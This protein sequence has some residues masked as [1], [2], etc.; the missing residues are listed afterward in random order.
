MH[1]HSYI[2][3]HSYICNLFTISLLNSSVSELF[4]TLFY[5]YKIMI[6]H[7]G[8]LSTLVLSYHLYFLSLDVWAV[9]R[10]IQVNS[11]AVELSWSQPLKPNGLLSHYQLLRD[12]VVVFSGDGGKMS[13]TD[14][15]LQP[16][17]R[18]Y[19]SAIFN[20]P[21]ALDYR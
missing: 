20:K 9:P 14:T 12:G 16:N 8:L 21:L 1:N 3:I 6:N 17:T 5:M 4:V 15:G 19:L 13:Y 10:H 18:F 7:S 2:Y 11:S